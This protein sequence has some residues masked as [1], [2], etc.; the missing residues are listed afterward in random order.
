MGH[1]RLRMARNRFAAT[2]LLVLSLLLVG[3]CGR[4]EAVPPP[5]AQA[6]VAALAQTSSSTTGKEASDGSTGIAG[7][8]AA[9]S[10]ATVTAPTGSPSVPTQR[11]GEGAVTVDVTWEN[12]A[13]SDSITFSV[14]MNT[15]SVE[16]DGYD[17]SKLASLRNGRGQEVK[18]RGWEA[19]PG[20]HHRSGL[21]T[22]PSSDGSGKPLLDGGSRRLELVIRDVAGVRERVLAWDFGG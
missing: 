5:S 4:S 19:P 6:V 15:H 1:G 12:S 7:T 2:L 11:N 21:L 9:R 18:P 22:F 3:G 13:D 16:L 14:A 17:L 20:G 10:T 8:T